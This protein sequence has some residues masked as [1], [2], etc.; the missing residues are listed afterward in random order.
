VGLLMDDGARC[1]APATTAD[2]LQAE[3]R[4]AGNRWPD[5]IRARWATHGLRA[6]TTRFRQQLGLPTDTPIVATGHQPTMWHPGILAKYFAAEEAAHRTSGAAVWLIADQ[7]AVDPFELRLPA[8]DANGNLTA[9]THRLGPAPAPGVAASQIPASAGAA[10]LN[11]APAL[12]AL[13]PRIDRIARLYREHRSAPSAAAQAGAVTAD[14]LRDLGLDGRLLYATALNTTDLFAK[15]IDSFRDDPDRTVRTYNA[16]VA[17]RPHAGVAPLEHSEANH[18][19]ELPLWR[20]RDNQ[21]RERV[22]EEDLGG[23]PTHE[24]APRAL[25]MTALLRLAGCE[26]FIHGSGGAEYDLVTEDWVRTWLGVEMAP[27]AMA[28]ATLRLPIGTDAPSQTDAEHAVWLA[29]HARHDPAAL[30]DDGF[31]DA[32][33][34][35]VK[36]IEAEREAGGDPAALFQAMQQALRDYRAAHISE[37]DQ[38]EASAEQM[39]RRTGERDI[40]CDRTW[41]FALHDRASLDALRATV[42]ASFN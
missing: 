19:H 3:V 39:Q 13:A 23:I 38:L 6:E 22:Y 29:H 33:R 35:Y 1:S 9:A 16:A 8:D 26:L 18:R 36:L 25:L 11:S 42:A 34:R 4:P 10:P 24:L 15:L 28:T 31:A 30:G 41:A 37:L 20:L 14:L 17:N 21:P 7:D 5:L 40:A 2:S 32:K 12:G 27:A